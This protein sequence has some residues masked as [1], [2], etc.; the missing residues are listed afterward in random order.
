M[1]LPDEVAPVFYVA[2][3]EIVTT[4][5]RARDLALSKPT[6][7]YHF[8][9][10]YKY[11]GHFACY[12]S[13]IFSWKGFQFRYILIGK[14]KIYDLFQLF[15]VYLCAYPSFGKLISH[16]YGEPIPTGVCRGI[17][18]RKEPE[19]RMRLYLLAVMFAYYQISVIV[20]QGVY[21]L[22]YLR[23]GQ[24]YFIQEHPPALLHSLY[25]G[26]V[27]PTLAGDIFS[28]NLGSVGMGVEVYPYEIVL[29]EAG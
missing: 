19:I 1:H 20:Q 11:P 23:L 10:L 14:V 24:V 22:K 12:I 26:A 2:E 28:D 4:Q 9:Y 3:T 13:Y 7:F 18:R 15:R 6:V 17:H 27:H 5:F 21:P 16:G 8:V 29:R 25:K